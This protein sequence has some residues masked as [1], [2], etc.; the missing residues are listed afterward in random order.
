MTVARARCHQPLRRGRGGSVAG[1]RCALPPRRIG[2]CRCRRAS[3]V[4]S[5]RVAP[6]VRLRHQ[7]PAPQRPAPARPSPSLCERP[8]ARRRGSGIV[9]FRGGE[10]LLER[11][12]G[13]RIEAGC[14]PRAAL[15]RQ[16]AEAGFARLANLAIDGDAPL[17]C[18]D[19]CG[20]RRQPRRSAQRGRRRF[21]RR[22]PSRRPSAAGRP[23]ERLSPNERSPRRRRRRRRRRPTSPSSSDG[24]LPR[25]L[26][27]ATSSFSSPDA[28]RVSSSS[29]STGARLLDD[30]RDVVRQ[31]FRR[32]RLRS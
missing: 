21:R 9:R 7:P 27:R 18:A 25:S 28:S 15:L 10:F 2:L 16:F 3:T 4:G 32:L 12:R 1:G 6:G 8:V 20:R 5:A 22:R 26:R 30:W 23:A 11:K 24:P 17:R 29:A 31:R 14:S 13:R 19:L